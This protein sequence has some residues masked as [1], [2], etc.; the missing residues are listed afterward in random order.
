MSGFK[1][2][3][4]RVTP[5]LAKTIGPMSGKYLSIPPKMLARYRLGD[6]GPNKVL[7]LVCL[8]AR[9]SAQHR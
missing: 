3:K 4:Y 2:W 6:I 5:Q 8:G 9:I 7:H 1:T